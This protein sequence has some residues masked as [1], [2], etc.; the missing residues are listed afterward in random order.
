MQDDLYISPVYRKLMQEYP[1]SH[2]R[3]CAIDIEMRGGMP[4]A[5]RGDDWLLKRFV[6]DE[7]STPTST[8]LLD[9]RESRF[10]FA[11]FTVQYSISCTDLFPRVTSRLHVQFVAARSAP[12]AS[13][14]T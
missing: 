7:I 9:R 12:P 14:L 10:D 8:N 2:V 3:P 6:D 13:R 11:N 5:L 1:A 4:L